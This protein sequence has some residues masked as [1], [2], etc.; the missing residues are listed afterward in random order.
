MDVWGWVIVYAIALALLQLLLY[1]VF[2][3]N[4]E[5]VADRGALPRRDA[6][7]ADADRGARRVDPPRE[8]FEALVG[9]SM[10]PHPDA[11]P[12]VADPDGRRVCPRCGAENEPDAEFD[13][14]W[15]CTNRL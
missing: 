11:E 8:R 13:R 12:L 6:E 5:S 2:V 10:G 9:N 1:R 4:G 15:N 3:D 7:D 14:C